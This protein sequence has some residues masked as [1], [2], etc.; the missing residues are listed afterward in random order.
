MRIAK[1]S[2]LA[3]LILIAGS[4]AWAAP[5]IDQSAN[6]LANGSFELGSLD[7]VTGHSIPSAADNW[8]QWSN[9]GLG[10]LLTSEL[11]TEAEMIS[12]Y[13]VG[14][15]DGDR[16]LQFTTGGGADGGFSFNTYGHPGWDV[17]GDVTF[18]GWVYVISGQM[19]FF[20]GSNATGFTNTRTLGTEQWEFISVSQSGFDEI[21]NEPL[22]YA[23][24]GPAEFIVDSVWLNEGLTPTHPSAP[25]P[26][27]ATMLLLGTGLVGLAGARRKFKK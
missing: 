27:P 23:T 1:V 4:A 2:L 16:A 18:S 5:F 12:N 8:S 26:E 25:V 19:G 3:V 20:I 22:L 14:L 7:P 9:S 13:G 21:N 24:G 15:I 10:D 11:I 6:L 17:N